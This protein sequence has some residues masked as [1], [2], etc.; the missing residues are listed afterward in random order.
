MDQQPKSPPFLPIALAILVLAIAAAATYMVVWRDNTDRAGN[1]ILQ[2]SETDSDQIHQRRKDI[3][4]LLAA[5]ETYASDHNGAY[6]TAADVNTIITSSLETPLIEPTTKKAYL[7]QGSPPSA[8][9]EV[10]YATYATCTDNSDGLKAASSK[11]AIAL[12]IQTAAKQYYCAS[13]SMTP[14]L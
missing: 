9:H 7:L 8:P 12:R 5:I 10:Q 13:N 4:K 2:S 3:A 6:P 14:L 11:Q 1:S